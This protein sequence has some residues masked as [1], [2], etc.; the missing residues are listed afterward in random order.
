MK[1]APKKT[2]PAKRLRENNKPDSLPD[3]LASGLECALG[4]LL[5][6]LHF[7]WG[8]KG[9]PARVVVEYQFLGGDRLLIDI[10]KPDAEPV[11]VQAAP[12]PDDCRV[13]LLP[14]D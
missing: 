3:R 10:G 1:T 13:E 7:C 11:H 12:W 8:T 14:S 6:A 4:D 2:K 5:Y 9:C